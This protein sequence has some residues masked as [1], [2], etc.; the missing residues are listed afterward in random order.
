[1]WR[2][3]FCMGK[4]G[5]I[6][7]DT[8]GRVEAGEEDSVDRERTKESGQKRA[9]RIIRMLLVTVYRSIV[10][11]WTFWCMNR[12]APTGRYSMRRVPVALRTPVR[13][14]RTSAACPHESV[15]ARRRPDWSAPRVRRVRRPLTYGPACCCASVRHRRTRVAT[16]VATLLPIA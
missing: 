16:T 15:R 6:T 1:M 11:E 10:L 7:D 3:A 12:V 4:R 14:R 2:R 9:R 8:R 5:A 13:R